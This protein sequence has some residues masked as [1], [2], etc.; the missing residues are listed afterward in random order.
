MLMPSS[1]PILLLILEITLN[2]L[3]TILLG[4]FSALP[5]VWFH[6]DVAICPDYGKSIV[7]STRGS[8]KLALVYDMKISKWG[9]ICGILSASIPH[10][11]LACTNFSS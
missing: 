7:R 9:A 6:A 2:L 3:T 5:Y 10:P 4:K 11:I 8:A 1:E